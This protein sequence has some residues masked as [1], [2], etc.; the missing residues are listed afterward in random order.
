M[1][2]LL[3]PLA[4]A[5]LLAMPACAQST[6]PASTTPAPDSALIEDLVAANRILYDQGVVD[7]FGHVSARSDKDPSHFLLARSMAPGLVEPEDILEFDLDGNAIDAQ[8]RALYLE[9]FIHSEIYKT[10]PEVKAIVHSHS[11]A[12]I[13][14]RRHRRGAQADL[15]HELVPWRGRTDLRDPRRR[16]RRHRHARAQRGAGRGTGGETRHIV[17]G[18]DARPW[19]RR[20]RRY[21]APGGVPRRLHRGQCQ[22]RIGR[23]ASRQRP[24]HLPQQQ[25]SGGRRQR[26]MPR[27]STALGICGRRRRWTAATSHRTLRHPRRGQ[28]RRWARETV[29]AVPAAASPPRRSPP[30]ETQLPQQI[31]PTRDE[32]AIALRGRARC[33]K[34]PD[35]LAAHRPGRHR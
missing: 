31:G 22:A 7:G 32:T 11:P 33:G 15:P 21:R 1:R 18:A 29:I 5:M 23:S 24:S 6:T 12:V 3:G 26:R 16:R 4:V 9:R 28:R 17:G 34:P 10:H 27:W 35:I 14:V 19:R 25:G 8:G 30:S 20:G 13:P 2:Q